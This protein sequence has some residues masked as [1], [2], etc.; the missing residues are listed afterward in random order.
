M[1]LSEIKEKIEVLKYKQNE[2]RMRELT[3]LKPFYATNEKEI[4]VEPEILEKFRK[5]RT[6]IANAMLRKMIN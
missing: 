3:V 1:D 4:E 5:Q 6:S 2:K